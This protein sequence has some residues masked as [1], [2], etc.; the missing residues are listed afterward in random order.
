MK[1]DLLKKILSIVIILVLII[2]LTIAIIFLYYKYKKVYYAEDF[3]IQRIYSS[4][5]KNGNGIDDYTDILL[6]ARK[7]AQNK[8]TYRSTYYKGGYPPDNEGVCTDVIW[9][10]FKNAGYPLKD[11]I[12]EDISKN[13]K[14]Y[15]A[16]NGRPDPNIDFRRVRNLKVYFEKICIKL[17]NDPTDIAE[18]QAGDIV[19]FG[20]SHIGIISDKR[21]KYGITYLIHNASQPEREEDTLIFW[22][23]IEPIT[24]HYRLK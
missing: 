20:S 5:D 11:M 13:V 19:I 17:T 16:V 3:G 4:N 12:D 8:P 18:W 2:L 15:P 14:D 22:N 7:D 1:K 10:A 23:N 9:R 6:G 24:G 21:N